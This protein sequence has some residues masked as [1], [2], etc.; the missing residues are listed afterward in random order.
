MPNEIV[1]NF[2]S[3]DLLLKLALEVV[4]H[5]VHIK[6]Q[7]VKLNHLVCLFSEFAIWMNSKTN[8]VILFF[9]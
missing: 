7:E 2:V 6:S 9:I 1:L 3:K 8:F 4:K 5:S